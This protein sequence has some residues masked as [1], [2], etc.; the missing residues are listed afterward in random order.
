MEKVNK[1][2]LFLFCVM[3]C[4]LTPTMVWSDSIVDYTI[5]S[6]VPLNQF[7]TV[8]GAFID[9]NSN[10]AGQLCSFYLKTLDGV[11]V[12]RADDQYTDSTGV[13]AMRFKVNE[14][15][16]KRDNNYSVF[17]VCGDANTSSNFAVMQRETI[18]EPASQEFEY[19]TNPINL[20]TVFV[21][22]IIIIAFCILL[23]APFLLYVIYKR[24]SRR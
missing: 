19:I 16:F 23:I 2:F 5:S 7:V 11:L 20:D 1:F 13:F 10:N 24:V 4:L 18:A 6:E 21:W 14:P 3:V 9:T 12:D 15:Y 8:T 17:T 22:A